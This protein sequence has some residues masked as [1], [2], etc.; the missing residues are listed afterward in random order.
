[1]STPPPHGKD[2]DATKRSADIAVNTSAGSPRSPEL[3]LTPWEIWDLL[4]AGN[5]RLVSQ[6][7]RHPRR[8]SE[9][10]GLIAKAQ[11]PRAVILS[12]SD[13]RVPSEIIFDQG[14][15]DI[16][17]VR[18]AGPIMNPSQLGSIEYAVEI[19]KASLVVVLAHERCGAITAARESRDA[20]LPGYIQTI[21]SG[22][23]PRVV[24]AEVLE[25]PK[26]HAEDLVYAL[27]NLSDIIAERLHE[28]TVGVVGAVYSL[29]SSEVSEVIR[30][31]D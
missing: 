16:F 8:D 23:S 20:P 2:V 29:D 31:T 10:R 3:A 17:V 4:Q 26:R 11:H 25:A 19:L 1:M 7:L 12:C 22:I 9:H 27:K 14:L 21:V 13:S 28:G 6:D 18:S 24:S 15:G 30:L 5:K